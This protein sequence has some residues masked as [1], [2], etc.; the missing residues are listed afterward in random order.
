TLALELDPANLPSPAVTRAVA[1][2]VEIQARYEGYIRRQGVQVE[3][4]SRMEAVEV[5]D[6]IDYDII[7]ALS[8]EGREK[9]SRVRPRSLGQAARIPGLRPG[10]VQVLYIHLEQRRRAAACAPI[11]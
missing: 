8:H 7:R 1:E 4:A 11:A 2:Q 3:Q 10:D 9:L 6:D 5:P